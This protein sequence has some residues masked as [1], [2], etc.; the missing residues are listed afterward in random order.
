M[1][2]TKRVVITDVKAVKALS[3]MAAMGD[4]DVSTIATNAVLAMWEQKAEETLKLVN[5]LS[6]LAHV[7][8]EEETVY[9]PE[10]D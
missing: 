4:E 2:G 8:D 10:I 1:A 6:P 5:D 7:L 9:S 3:L